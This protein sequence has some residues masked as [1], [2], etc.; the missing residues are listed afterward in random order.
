MLGQREFA[1]VL[2]EWP[3]VARKLLTQLAIRLRDAEQ[4]TA[5]H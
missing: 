2:D 1:A 3:G 5:T 4:D